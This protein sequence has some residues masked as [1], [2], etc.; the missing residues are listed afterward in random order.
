MQ[1]FACVDVFGI[2]GRSNVMDILGGI[3]DVVA[4][5]IVGGLAAMVIWTVGF[6]VVWATYLC[7]AIT[8]PTHGANI[9]TKIFDGKG[10]DVI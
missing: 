3:R 7:A 8:L 10:S 4:L 5:T 9:N 6:M 2:V 1:I